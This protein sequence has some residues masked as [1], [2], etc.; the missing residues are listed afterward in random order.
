MLALHVVGGMTYKAI[1]DEWAGG[2][3]GR[4]VELSESAV[5]QFIAKVAR[6]LELPLPTRRGRRSTTRKAS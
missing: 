1:A 2:F 6:E 5:Q 4:S 3:G